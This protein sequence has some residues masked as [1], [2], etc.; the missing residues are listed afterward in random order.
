MLLIDPAQDGVRWCLTTNGTRSEGCFPFDTGWTDALA[1]LCA[2]EGARPLA[3]RLHHGGDV[4]R[5]PAAFIDDEV[6]RAVDGSVRFMPEMNDMTARIA[7]QAV[8]ALGAAGAILLCETAFFLD[9]PV[10]AALYAVPENLRR[11]GLRRAGGFGLAHAWGWRA[12]KAR[13]PGARRVVSVLLSDRTNCAAI[14]DGRPLE[15][16][17]G[18]SA[19]EGIVSA[20][21]CGDID[22]TIVFQL[23]AHG[24]TPA[25][26]RLVL[27]QKSG[28]TGLL[29][30]PCGL[31][32]LLAARGEAQA[33]SV[34]ELYSYQLTKAIGAAVSVLG[35]L[36]VLV[37]MVHAPEDVAGLVSQIVDR[38]A[39]LGIRRR[40]G[41]RPDGETVTEKGSPVGVFCLQY[42]K[43]S[44]LADAAAQLR[45]R[46]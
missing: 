1:R 45:S 27:S 30:R 39:W 13:A 23:L 31:G 34:L 10:E 11:Q 16:T 17:I 22:P 46:P 20:T 14:L 2:R 9:L 38:L 32:D 18:F 37:F 42:D 5:Q 8:G 19:V 15:T 12:V 36:D 6:L 29:G 28:F 43:W 33:D 21:G 25:D 26:V 24:M 35:G 44:V 41:A 40:A 4:V 3:V 7:R